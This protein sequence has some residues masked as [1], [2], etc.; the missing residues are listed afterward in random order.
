MAPYGGMERHVCSLA[1]VLAEQGHRVRLL[2]TTP[3]YLVMDTS[4]T[5]TSG[6]TTTLP[7]IQLRYNGIPV[8]AGLHIQYDTM[9]QIVTLIWNKPT[10]GTKIK[11]YTVFRGNAD[12]NKTPTTQI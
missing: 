5:V 8:P 10:T 9:K 4:F 1:R 7:P 12:S 11:G 2:T 6:I 3:N